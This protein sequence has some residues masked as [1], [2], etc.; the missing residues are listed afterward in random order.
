MAGPSKSS[1]SGRNDAKCLRYKNNS[2]QELNQLRR[3]IRHVKRQSRLIEGGDP[4]V[5]R[6]SVWGK[7][8]AAAFDRI[9]AKVPN[10]TIKN[11]CA[12]LH[13]RLA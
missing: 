8:V 3:L 7:D 2:T 13:V 11:V 9:N 4:G 12:E 10:F 1:K 5:F 6:P